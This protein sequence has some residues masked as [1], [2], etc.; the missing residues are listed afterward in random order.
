MYFSFSYFLSPM[1]FPGGSDGKASASNAGDPGSIPGS[2]YYLK[3]FYITTHKQFGQTLIILTQ[4]HVIFQREVCYSFSLDP[5]LKVQLPGC[6]LIVTA[7][8]LV[9]K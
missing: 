6:R 5:V 1:N 7:G 8:K 9:E 4:F 2:A 3:S